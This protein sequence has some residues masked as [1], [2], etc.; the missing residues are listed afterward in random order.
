MASVRIVAVVLENGV[1][2]VTG[3]AWMSWSSLPG[4]WCPAP[5]APPPPPVVFPLSTPVSWSSSKEKSDQGHLDGLIS[6]VKGA[7][8][9]FDHS[10]LQ[11]FGYFHFIYISILSASM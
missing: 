8:L 1:T 4:T 5:L 10:C 3:K 7:S 2:V 6:S 11:K 9:Y